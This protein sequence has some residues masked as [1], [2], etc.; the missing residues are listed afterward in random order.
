MQTNVTWN[1]GNL[2]YVPL[3]PRNRSYDYQC[4]ES[5]LSPAPSL[6]RD[7]SVISYN[8]DSSDITLSLRW[9]PPSTPNGILTP[10]N[11]CIGAEPLEP[12]E[13]VHPNRGYVCGTLDV[14]S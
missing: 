5:T 8:V 14:S 2:V 4:T 9:S 12:D 7:L 1:T 6:V 10:Y 11:I 13:E 3:R